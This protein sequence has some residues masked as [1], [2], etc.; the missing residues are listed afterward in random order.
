MTDQADTNQALRAD[1]DFKRLGQIP[2]SAFRGLMDNA[3]LHASQTVAADLQA[4]TNPWRSLGPRNIGGR[5][6]ALALHPRNGNIL[7]AGSALGGV[8]K[9]TDSGDSW[10]VLDDF[11]PANGARQAL[12]VG[13]IAIAP[14]NPDVVYVGTGEPVAGYISGNGLFRSSNGGTHFTQIDHPDSG[15]IGAHRYERI[16]VDPWDANRVWCAAFNKGLWRSRPGSF[17]GFQQ[18]VIDAPGAPAAAA[19]VATDIVVNWGDPRGVRPNRYT[20]FVALRGAGVYQATFIHASDA[21]DATGATVWTQVNIPGLA[22]LPSFKRIKLALCETQPRRMYCV[23]GDNNDR[24]SNVFRSNDGGGNWA[25]TTAQPGS[26]SSITWYSLV[27]ECSPSDPNVVFIGQVDMW[28]T[29]DGGT[30]WGTPNP[31]PPPPNFQ[32]CLDRRR[33]GQGDR[34]QHADQQAVAFDR[35]RPH[36]AWVGNDGGVS[37]TTDLGRIWR[38]RSHGILATQ[39]N[40][41]STHPQYPFMMGGGLQDNGCW[42]TYGGLSWYHIG[43]SDG[44]DVGFDPDS[45]RNWYHSAQQGIWRGQMAVDIPGSDFNRPNPAADMPGGDAHTY[46]KF[47]STGIAAADK[48]PFYAVLVHHPNNP[49]EA[50]IGRRNR[51][52]RSTNGTSFS[53]LGHAAFSGANNEACALAYGPDPDNDWWVA[54]SAGEVFYTPDG[55][56]NWRNAIEP[57]AARGNWISA[58]ATHPTNSAM[59]AIAVASRPGT[60]YVTGN[61]G[62][63]WLEISGRAGAGGA[64]WAA[65]PAGG[66]AD[67]L[68]PGPATAVAF[69][70]TAS[71]NTADLQ[72]LYVGTLTG[73]YVIRNARVPTTAAP[74][75]AFQPVWRTYNAQLPLV[76]IYDMETVQFQDANGTQHNR[77]RIAT[78]GRGIYEA[79]LNN[80]TATQLLVRQHVDDNGLRLPAPNH[81]DDDPRLPALP[82]EADTNL[83]FDRAIDI[84][85]DAPPFFDFGQVADSVE[86]DQQLRNALPVCAEMN[87]IYVQVSNIGSRPSARVQVSLYWAEAPGDP[88]AAPDLPANFWTGY[89]QANPA[90]WSLVGTEETTHLTSGAPAILKFQWQPMHALPAN[91]ALLALVHDNTQDSLTAT[92]PAAFDIPTLVGTERRA[93]L[94]ITNTRV[95]PADGLLR[96]GFDDQ[97]ALGETAWG[98]RSHD[99]IVVQTAEANP[100]AAFADTN[101]LRQDDV[102]DGSGTN[103][104]YIRVRNRGCQIRNNVQVEVFRI[105][106]DSIA[107]FTTWDSLGTASQATLAANTT[108]LMPA[109]TWANP[110]D[111]APSKVHLLAALVQTTEEPRPDPA[112]QINSIA[113]FWAFFLETADSNNAALRGLH[114]KP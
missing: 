15:S 26:T 68:N 85:V 104:I 110:P 9:T 83:T 101:D 48:P 61:G 70:P 3:V 49:A 22:A 107:D 105:P 33:Y 114:W 47:L 80:A 36:L 64:N 76:L 89:P 14:S 18:D 57:I 51:A 111:P 79:D 96:D 84:R 82:A 75:P 50:M 10:S 39:F 7:Y 71:N 28:C 65:R 86:F 11:R 103:H 95:R 13:A 66:A 67:Q 77:L 93:A 12:P 16:R 41:I 23:A 60:L 58:I 27:L 19:Q 34:A 53:A 88:P 108:T 21:Y 62:A 20:V 30:T 81:M 32:P 55:G 91:L 25:P 69:H 38:K 74:T 43:H 63:N 1:A 29:K 4:A 46:G 94:R 54:T 100:N 99:I 31:N 92:P 56:T 17:P 52:Y 8:W 24:F 40:D 98:A 102:L 35:D 59:A 44:G 90:P 97:G 87:L 2:Q 6:R 113:T 106:L 73:V 37:L 5:I 42:L 112:T 109:I 72:T 78:F 45:S